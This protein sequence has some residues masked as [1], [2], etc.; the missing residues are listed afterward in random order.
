MLYSF[1]SIFCSC[2]VLWDN[3]FLV[4]AQAAPDE[5]N[6]TSKINT[7]L[8]V[9]ITPISPHNLC[10]MPTICQ[11]GHWNEVIVIFTQKHRSW[12]RCTLLVISPINDHSVCQTSHVFTWKKALFALC[13]GP[14]SFKYVKVDEPGHILPR[15]IKGLKVGYFWGAEINLVWGEYNFSM[16]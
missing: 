4:F 2:K 1:L 16:V 11:Q 14:V 7:I 12:Q 3:V 13:T 5:I 8:C 6:S 9:L 15:N 10:Q